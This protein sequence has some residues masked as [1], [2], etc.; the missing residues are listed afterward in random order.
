MFYKLFLRAF[1]NHFRP[2]SIYAHFPFVIPA[3]NHIILSD[4]KIVDRYSWDKPSYIPP[5]TLIKTYAACKS[6]SE[7]HNDFKVT[8][9][10]AIEFLM[11][12]SGKEYGADFMLSGDMP[13]NAHSR[14]IMCKTLYHEGWM[15]E[16]K[17]F[18]EN[19]TLQLL[20]KHSYKISG[21]NQ[22]DIV[23]DVANPAQAHFAAEVSLVQNI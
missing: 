11:H 16:V 12:N 2:N 4:L 3:E 15:K 18:Y 6:I 1:P 23:R 5:P 9:G 20:R 22:V 13:V 10:K 17:S 8:W 21:A 19:I 7:N 14:N